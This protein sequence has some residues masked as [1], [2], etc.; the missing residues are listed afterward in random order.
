M[1]KGGKEDIAREESERECDFLRGHCF[2]HLATPGQFLWTT[3]AV[4]YCSVYFVG[5][6]C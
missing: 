3:A 1:L 4:C 6:L 2:S 5:S